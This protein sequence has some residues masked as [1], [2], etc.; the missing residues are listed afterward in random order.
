MHDLLLHLSIFAAEMAVV[1]ISTMPRWLGR[2]TQKVPTVHH[3][4]IRRQIR[5]V[6]RIHGGFAGPGWSSAD[7]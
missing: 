6:T 1:A 2:L 7:R 5:A 4:A 3:S